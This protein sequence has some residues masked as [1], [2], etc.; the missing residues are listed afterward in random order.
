MTCAS[1][2]AFQNDIS[3]FFLCSRKIS[4]GINYWQVDVGVK[5]I[6]FDWI[7]IG[8]RPIVDGLLDT[9]IWHMALFLMVLL[10]LS[11]KGWEPFFMTCTKTVL[12][13][14][15]IVRGY[16]LS[17]PSCPSRGSDGFIFYVQMPN[18]PD[19]GR[20]WEIV[21][22]YNVSIFYTAPTAIRSLMRSGDQVCFPRPSVL[23]T[24]TFLYLFRTSYLYAVKQI[25]C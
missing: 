3:S 11:L 20:C 7:C 13:I 21:D 10:S 24:R 14:V 22:K 9:A 1:L 19:A 18:Y 12:L 2:W 25:L 15:S 23:C 4:H 16:I 17:S 6:T 8:V 5:L